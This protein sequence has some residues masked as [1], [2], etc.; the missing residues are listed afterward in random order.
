MIYSNDNVILEDTSLLEVNFFEEIDRWKTHNQNHTISKFKSNTI[1]DADYEM[2]KDLIMTMR[3]CEGYEEYS[4]AFNR[5]CR[6]CHV[7]PRGVIIRR[8]DLKRGKED[9]NSLYVEYTYNTKKMTLPEGTI[10]YHMSSVPDITELKP[11]FRGKSGRGYLYDKPRIYFTIRKNMPK[12][13]ADYRGKRRNEKLHMYICK[14]PIKNVYVDPLVWSSI[15]G[16][17]YIETN[18]PVKVEELTENSKSLINKIFPLSEEEPREKEHISSRSE[19]GIIEEETGFDMNHFLNF[20][21]EN[22]LE[23]DQK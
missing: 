16:A 13:L 21:S 2:L 6:Y 18:K 9:R 7:L 4:K 23:L 19:S 22:G 10:L 3:E 14:E 20:I 8:Y 17:V 1:S 15:Q 12:F 11:F 5:F